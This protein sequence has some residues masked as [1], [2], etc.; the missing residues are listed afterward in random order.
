MLPSSP[1]DFAA[2]DRCSTMQLICKTVMSTLSDELRHSAAERVASWSPERSH[3]A[4]WLGGYPRLST[5]MR[6]SLRR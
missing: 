2:D 1:A 4:D 6:Y 5:A 3:D